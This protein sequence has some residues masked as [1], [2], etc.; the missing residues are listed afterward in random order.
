MAILPYQVEVV[1]EE[2]RDQVLAWCEQLWPHTKG[3]TWSMVETGK[4]Q[5]TVYGRTDILNGWIYKV[6]F[7]REEDFL[8]Y[9]ITWA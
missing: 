6:A 8:L 2:Q 9:Q 1:G 3:A 5:I 7:Q 4:L